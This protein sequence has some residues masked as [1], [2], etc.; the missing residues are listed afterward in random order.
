MTYNGEAKALTFKKIVTF[1]SKISNES[2]LNE[3]YTLTEFSYQHEKIS[4][5]EHGII[6]DL[7]LRI[8]CDLGIH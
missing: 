8:N 6:Y 3:A 7:L 1:I 2:E 5:V 4:W